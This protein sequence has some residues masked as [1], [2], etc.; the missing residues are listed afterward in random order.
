MC[1]GLFRGKK[2]A[3][4]ETSDHQSYKH[5]AEDEQMLNRDQLCEWT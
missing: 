2:V 4:D 5:G 3:F 1:Q